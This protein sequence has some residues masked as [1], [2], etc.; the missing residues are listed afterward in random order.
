MGNGWHCNGMLGDC[1][2]DPDCPC[3]CECCY[4]DGLEGQG[5][6]GEELDKRRPW[7][8]CGCEHCEA[9]RARVDINLPLRSEP[10]T[11][12]AT[13][14]H[15]AVPENPESMT[16]NIVVGITHASFAS[17]RSRALEEVLTALEREGIPKSQRFLQIDRNR[18]GSLWCWRELM[19]WMLGKDRES[20]ERIT[21]VL[22][23]ADDTPPHPGF[24]LLVPWLARLDLAQP[25]PIDLMVNTDHPEIV[26]LAG[27]PA[28]TLYV[29]ADGG[30]TGATLWPVALLRAHLAWRERWLEDDVADDRGLNLWAIAEG[31]PVYKP[32]RSFVEHLTHITPAGTVGQASFAVPSLDGHD[33]DA[34][35]TPLH[36]MTAEIAAAW[37][38]TSSDDVRC[39]RIGRTYSNIQRELFYRRKGFREA[40][41]RAALRLAGDE[42]MR[43]TGDVADALPV[44]SAL[45]NLESTSAG[46]YERARNYLTPELVERAYAV[47]R[48]GT[49]LDPKGV[50]I[51]CPSYRGLRCEVALAM[52]IAEAELRE[53]GYR[54]SYILTPGASLVTR[55]RHR[56]QHLFMQSDCSFLLSWDDDVVPLDPSVVRR[57]VGL[58][59]EK[60][61][62]ILAGAYPLRGRDA[63]AVAAN[64]LV[65]GDGRPMLEVAE[66][67]TAKVR[68]AATGFLLLK[69]S[70]LADLMA[71]HP[72]RYYVDTA[73]GEFRYAPMWD[74]FSTFVDPGEPAGSAAAKADP[75]APPWPTY[76]SEDYGFCS[77]A[78]AAGYDVRVLMDA[79]FDHHGEGV[80][81]GSAAE[82]W[83][84]KAVLNQQASKE[85]K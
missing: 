28:P 29:S 84:P 32:A 18:K 72:E 54:V 5:F 44:V 53:A 50:A 47:E 76:R 61:Y 11:A 65:D 60:G 80:Y 34:H 78:R 57:M 13:P 6:V 77:L 46:D 19:T 10:G 67:G 62:P 81:R 74:L 49:L 66:D 30:A 68:D 70:L 83:M 82:A 9:K 25:G 3:R 16:P 8:N 64:P 56:I 73:H 79:R 24:G 75:S 36:P 38:R 42:M 31:V 35:R 59:E 69:R 26:R 14:S 45:M 33:A 58:M 23:L 15:H 37:A 21:H 39:V 63:Q 52:Q 2:N 43:A 40:R 22:R 1:P 4:C 48:H 41:A 20:K 7:P 85:G 51:S 27:E 71:R 17:S 12:T 55:A